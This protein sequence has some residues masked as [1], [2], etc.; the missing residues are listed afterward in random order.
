MNVGMVATLDC[1]RPV[2]KLATRLVWWFD[3][4]RAHYLT[5]EA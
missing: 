4:T 3:S 5:E 1:G 2:R